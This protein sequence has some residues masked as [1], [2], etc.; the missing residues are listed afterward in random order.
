MCKCSTCRSGARRNTERTRASSSENAKW[1]YQIIIGA[2]LE[3]F[4]PV[5]HT[6]AGGKKKNGRT[7]PVAPQFRHYLP[8]IFVW[9]HDIDD[10]KIELDRARALQTGFTIPRKIDNETGLPQAFC[11]KSR[12][13]RFVLDHQNAH[14]L[15]YLSHRLK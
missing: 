8:A 10:K 9:Q 14:R 2:Q 13:F 7:N 1:L 5:A 6:V 4:H 3:S 12:R 11:Q 15:M